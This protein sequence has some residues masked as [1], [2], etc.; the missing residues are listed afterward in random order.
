M[1][2]TTSRSPNLLDLLLQYEIFKTF[3]SNLEYNDLFNVRRLSKSLSTNYSAFN[4]ARWDIN[5]FLKRFVKDPRGL[6]S[7]MA[8]IGAIITGNA[9]LQFLDR[10]VWPGTDR[11]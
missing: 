10:V 11:S 8:Q 6:R 1:A 3:C 7:F 2:D 9:A 4:K 5:R